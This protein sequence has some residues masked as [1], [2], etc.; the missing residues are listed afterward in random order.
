MKQ[1]KETIQ[2][3]FWNYLQKL[4]FLSTFVKLDR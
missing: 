4:V 2:I 1:R 3:D